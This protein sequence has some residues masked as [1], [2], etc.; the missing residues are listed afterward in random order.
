GVVLE[1]LFGSPQNIA[2]CLGTDPQKPM[3]FEFPVDPAVETRFVRRM[4]Q[5]NAALGIQ[6]CQRW[7]QQKDFADAGLGWHKFYQGAQGPAPSR[8]FMVKG[9][10]TR[11]DGGL[12]RA[13]KLRSPP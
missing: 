8:Q 13:R 4:D 6:P 10:E 7:P 9:I 12:A 11:P 5:R 1:Y 3:A 2:V